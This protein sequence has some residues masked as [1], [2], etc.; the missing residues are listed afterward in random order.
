M[1]EN[2]FPF[3]NL[4]D[5]NKDGEIDDLERINYDID[6]AI[7]EENIG[8]DL[9]F[10]PFDELDDDI[11][12]DENMDEEYLDD[13]DDEIVPAVLTVSFKDDYHGKYDDLPKSGM[14]QY[15]NG[16]IG[17]WNFVEALIDN[18]TELNEYKYSSSICDIIKDVMEKDS[19]RAVWYVDWLLANFPTAMLTRTIDIELGEYY[20]NEIRLRSIS[21]LLDAKL[22]KDNYIYDKIKNGEDYIES[23]FFEAKHSESLDDVLKYLRFM[24]MKNDIPEAIVGYKLCREAQEDRYTVED[25]AEMLSAIIYTIHD[26]GVT[27]DATVKASLKSLIDELT[28]Y[29]EDVEEIFNQYIN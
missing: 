16:E 24:V 26:Y 13:E 11:N 3:D 2:M 4:Y 19:H 27:I 6:N 12:F 8:N 20:L 22:D 28:P 14:W 5:A 7:E 15:F 1:D 17:F 9:D 25:F 18:F 21:S 23:F 10:P 29:S